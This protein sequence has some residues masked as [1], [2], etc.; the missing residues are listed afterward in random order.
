MDLRKAALALGLAATPVLT[1][2]PV[3]ADFD[4]ESYPPYERCA[5]CHG[6]FGVS[7][8]P[9]FPHLGGQKPAYLAA[10][11]RAFL[12][13]SRHNDGGQMSAIVTELAAADIPVAVAWF[14]SQDPPPPTGQTAATTAYTDFGC[15]ACHDDAAD[16]LA[17]HLTA[18]HPE[19]LAKQMED[20]RT[21]RRDGSDIAD[22]HRALLA[23]RQSDIAPMA[24]HLAATPRPESLQ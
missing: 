15:A 24:H 3:L 9:R 10:Q 4:A 5:L 21:G 1:A 17:P 12:D 16:P 14:A 6:L 13:G 20:F 11:I 23:D 7:A 22:M 18:Q 19:Y 8:N 2:T